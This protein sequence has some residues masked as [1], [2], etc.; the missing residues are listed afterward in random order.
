MPNDMLVFIQLEKETHAKLCTKK[1]IWQENR[2]LLLI[3]DTDFIN[4]VFYKELN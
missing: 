1:I 2:G 4:I 3:K